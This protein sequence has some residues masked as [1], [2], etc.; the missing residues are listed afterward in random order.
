MRGNIENRF[1]MHAAEW[2]IMAAVTVPVKVLVLEAM[3]Y[4]VI[5]M[6]YQ[7]E[8]GINI[9]QTIKMLMKIPWLLTQTSL[10][11][12]EHFHRQLH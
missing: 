10:T 6:I 9:P 3:E 11:A 12:H 5:R 4:I 2:A 8:C 1:K 7:R